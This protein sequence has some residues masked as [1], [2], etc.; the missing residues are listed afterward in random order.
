VQMGSVPGPAL[1][2]AA[3]RWIPLRCSDRGAMADKAMPSVEPLGG[4]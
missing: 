2:A 1:A 3:E 4:L